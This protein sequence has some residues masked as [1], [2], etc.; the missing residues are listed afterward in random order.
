[1]GR[2]LLPLGKANREG[3]GLLPANHETF[4]FWLG[5]SPPPRAWGSHARQPLQLPLRAPRGLAPVQA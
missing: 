2:W 4:L 1:M 5:N 3:L